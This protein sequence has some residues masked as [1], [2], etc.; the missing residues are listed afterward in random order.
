MV[1]SVSYQD[2]L[3]E[4]L[5]DPEEAVGYLNASLEAGDINTFLL[6]LKNVIKAQG[7]VTKIAKNAHK[8]RTSIYK[9][10]SKT[11]NPHLKNMADILSA[12][13][14]HLSVVTNET[15]RYCGDVI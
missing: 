5:R 8:S 2:Y 6:A 15:R 1:K 7:G 10:F 9:A 3:I 13:N 12:L 4:S 14:M 11:G